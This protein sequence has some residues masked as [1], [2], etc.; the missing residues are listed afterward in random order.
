MNPE[1]WMDIAYN[2]AGVCEV[3]GKR[4]NPRIEEYFATTSYP[5]PQNYTDEVAWCGAFV[6]WVVEQ[7]GFKGPQDAAWSQAWRHWGQGLRS[8]RHGAIV[9]FHWGNDKGH[10]GFIDDWDERGIWVLGGNQSDEVNV[11]KFG[12]SRVVAYRW[13]KEA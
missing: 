13:P 12:Y 11:T 9:V 5:S 6:N 10:V 2:E 7:A 8:I 4:D 3:P 1:E